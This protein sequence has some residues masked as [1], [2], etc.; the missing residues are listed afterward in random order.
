MGPFIDILAPSGGCVAWDATL[1]LSF[2][3]KR[4]IIIYTSFM[5]TKWGVCKALSTVAGTVVGPKT[6]YQKYE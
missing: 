2:I 3:D 1:N 4:R 5:G 6:N